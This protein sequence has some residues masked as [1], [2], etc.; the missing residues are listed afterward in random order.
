ML[1]FLTAALAAIPTAATSRLAFLAYLA[2][3]VSWVVVAYRVRSIQHANISVQHL[4]ERD[5]LE[6][7]MRVYGELR[8]E[9]LAPDQYIKL[10][11]QQYFF[12]GVLAICAT[13]ILVVGLA[14]RDALDRERLTD[15]LIQAALL[16]PTT[17]VMSAVNVLNLGPNGVAELATTMQPDLS[18]AELAALIDQWRVEEGLDADQSMARFRSGSQGARLQDVNQQ[19]KRVSQRINGNLSEL[20]ECF[21]QQRCVASASL[22]GELCLHLN[23]VITDMRGSNEAAMSVPGVTFGQSGSDPSFG[24]GALDRYFEEITIPN[25]TYLVQYCG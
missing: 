4:P 2:A 18:E 12:Y 21:R 24:D 11:K 10:K 5:R 22:I 20:A 8:V 14:A 3:I 19:L 6:Y 16:P 9:V 23:R 13:A 15:E 25:A 7:L 1:D 17:D